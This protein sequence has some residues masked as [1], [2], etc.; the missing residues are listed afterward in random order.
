[1]KPTTVDFLLKYLT[2]TARDIEN[3]QIRIKA[4]ETALQK[5]EPNAYQCYLSAIEKETQAIART[6]QSQHEPVTVAV[7]RAMLLQDQE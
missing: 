6:A 1:M 3:C 2:D 5:Y 4:F 7:L